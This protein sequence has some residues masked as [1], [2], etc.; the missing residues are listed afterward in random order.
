MCPPGEE[1]SW[2][3]TSEF[4]LDLQNRKSWFKHLS[5]TKITFSFATLVSR[6][7][8]SENLIEAISESPILSFPWF[9]SPF[10]PLHSP[11]LKIFAIT[12]LATTKTLVF[13]VAPAFHPWL[14]A[15]LRKEM[16]A[17]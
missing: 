2:L 7:C 11:T 5:Q 14:V 4:Y 3:V 13:G 16:L 12:D 15:I 1:M 17:F 9:H 10:I 8:F 6:E